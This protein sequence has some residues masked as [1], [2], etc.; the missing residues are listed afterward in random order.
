MTHESELHVRT[1]VRGSMTVA[2]RAAALRDDAPR[3]L[4]LGVVRGGRVVEERLFRARAP[5]TTGT[6]ER[7]TIVVAS[8]EAREHTLLEPL[9]EAGYRLNLV[10]GLEGRVAQSDGLVDLAA[11]RGRSCV[12]LGSDARGRLILGDVTLLFQFV[13]APPP[14]ARPQLP[15]GVRTQLVDAIDWN[16]VVLCALSFLVHFGF[17][18]AMLSDWMDAPVAEDVASARTLAALVDDTRVLPTTAV[19][20]PTTT[21]EARSGSASDAPSR[22][23]SAKSKPS[24]ARATAPSPA[25]AERLAARAEQLRL[26]L[27]ESLNHGPAIARTLDGRDVPL[28]DLSGPARSEIGARRATDALDLGSRSGGVVGPDAQKSGLDR[29]ATRE[30]TASDRAGAER[31]VAAPRSVAEIGHVEGT[32]TI[33]DGERVVAS[34]R[35]RFRR[36]YERGLAVEPSLAGSVTLVANV[37]ANGEVTAAEPAGDST[38]GPAVT[39]CL[40]NVVKSA[41]FAPPGGA[42][43][44][45]RIP[46]KFVQQSR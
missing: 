45:L 7:C 28:P 31:G 42:G 35:V 41:N 24:A 37:G 13:P 11:L 40:V 12:L 43:A 32:S 8:S 25:D 20:Q 3:V 26:D 29:L 22:S 6:S 23:A 30:G 10:P 33:G 17:V 2:M 16:L 9:D 14:A 4:R 5:V 18:G 1:H 34:L 44:R 38:L 15:L 21:T 39:A 36:C 19:E 27:L 46:I